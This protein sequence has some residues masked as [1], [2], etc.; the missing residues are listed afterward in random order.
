VKTSL[1]GAGVKAS[2]MVLAE[3]AELEDA[4]SVA[5]SAPLSVKKEEEVSASQLSSK[6]SKEYPLIASNATDKQLHVCKFPSQNMAD[7][8][9]LSQPVHMYRDATSL[10]DPDTDGHVPPHKATHLLAKID[11]ATRRRLPWV[12]DDS[13]HSTAYTGH[14]QGGQTSC[15]A[16]LYMQSNQFYI[17]PVQDWYQFRARPSF[18]ALS[19]E[20][21]EQAMGKMSK[22][23]DATDRWL[24][25]KLRRGEEGREEKPVADVKDEEEVALLDPD[26]ADKFAAFGRFDSDTE[27]DKDAPGR[28]ASDPARTAARPARSARRAVKKEKGDDDDDDEKDDDE[29]EEEEEE[30]ESKTQAEDAEGGMDYNE[31]MSDDDESMF[32]NAE[33]PDEKTDSDMKRSLT[34]EGLHMKRLIEQQQDDG[35]EDD[36][37]DSE[38]DDID[39]E[40]N[41]LMF[42]PTLLNTSSTASVPSLSA[43]GTVKSGTSSSST[44]A[45][46]PKVSTSS[47]ATAAAQKPKKSKGDAPTD[48]KKRPRE[49]A[50][51]SQPKKAKVEV[52]EEDGKRHARVTEAE[53][54]ALMRSKGKVKIEDLTKLFRVGKKEKDKFLQMAKNLVEL[55]KVGNEKWISLKPGI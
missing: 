52:K 10:T 37:E 45:V 53:F 21:A 5:P 16:M 50:P 2:R 32:V 26:D 8:E 49:E 23:R 17:R 44:S 28:R 25:S 24:M 41:N 19:I 15:Y 22:R 11:A 7:L 40:E 43:A 54:I 39:P 31:V 6:P 12:V 48:S 4:L 30:E 35:E 33:G 55:K 27:K 13:D 51:A 14:L 9:K 1:G 47:T 29:D 18:H 42:G 38:D 20:E 3:R 34:R 36:S 46:Q